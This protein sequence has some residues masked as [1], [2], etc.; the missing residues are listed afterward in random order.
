MLQ[1]TPTEQSQ[2]ALAA[3]VPEGTSDES[4]RPSTSGE[5]ARATAKTWQQHTRRQY[6]T[7]RSG[8]H[9]LCE[10]PPHLASLVV[11][12]AASVPGGAYRVRDCIGRIGRVDRAYRARRWIA[13]GTSG[14]RSAYHSQSSAASA[15]G[16]GSAWR[17]STVVVS[18]GAGTGRSR[19]STALSPSE[20]AEEP[21]IVPQ[22]FKGS[23]WR[24]WT[25][26]CTSVLDSMVPASAYEEK[27]TCQAQY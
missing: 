23:A 14:S 2:K 13:A 1:R 20:V 12:Y 21:A 25:V 26:W 9:A 4:A 17:A 15:T 22:S 24:Y 11:A 8:C 7:F 5:S 27:G 10:L 16:G 6:R 3:R 18:L 19:V